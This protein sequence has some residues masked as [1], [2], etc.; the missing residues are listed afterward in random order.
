MWYVY[1]AELLVW[2]EL[3]VLIICVGLL[4]TSH[5]TVCRDIID[6]IGTAVEPQEYIERCHRYRYV[7]PSLMDVW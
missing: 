2:L 5:S 3:S 4:Q 1:T 7:I 6:I